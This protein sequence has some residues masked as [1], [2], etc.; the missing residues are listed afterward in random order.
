MHLIALIQSFMALVVIC[1][2]FGKYGPNGELYFSFA[3]LSF[4]FSDKKTD[5]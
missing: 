2:R 1:S 5:M 4:L 3:F